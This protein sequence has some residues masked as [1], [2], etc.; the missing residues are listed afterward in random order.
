M[1]LRCDY[2]E[3]CR[4]AQDS[5]AAIHAA[6]LRSLAEGGAGLSGTSPSADTMPPGRASAPSQLLST[7][8]VGPRPLIA[9]LGVRMGSGRAVLGEARPQVARVP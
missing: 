7:S 9:A 8:S 2:A 5:T 4:R 3:R 1:S 6:G